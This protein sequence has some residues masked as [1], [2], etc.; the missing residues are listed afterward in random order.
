MSPQDFFDERTPETSTPGRK[1]LSQ[2]YQSVDSEYDAEA[3]RALVR[4]LDLRLMPLAIWMYLLCY[5]DRS[6]RNH[7]N[8]IVLFPP[9]S[10]RRLRV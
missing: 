7:E 1:S 5:L 3:H 9:Y 2:D 8:F 4:R 6:V 10:R